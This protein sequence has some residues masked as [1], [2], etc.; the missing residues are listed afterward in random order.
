MMPLALSIAHSLSQ[1]LAVRPFAGR[2]VGRFERACN[3]VDGA[4]R[5]VALTLPEVGNGPFSIVISGNPGLFDSL[6]INQQAAADA[7]N[8]TIGQWQ[9]D[10][11]TAKIWEPKLVC[12]SQPLRLSSTITDSLKALTGWP[13]SEENSSILSHHLSEAKRRLNGAL[14]S[15]RA[16]GGVGKIEQAVSQLAGLGSGLT[17]AGDD[18]LMGVM[19]ALWLKG[20]REPLPG[21]AQVAAPR[22]TNLSAAFLKAAARGEYLELWHTLAQTLYAG[23]AEA[24]S[25][26][27]ERIAQFGASSGQEALAGFSITLLNLVKHEEL[28]S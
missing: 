17:P 23:E 27:V 6:P 15:A 13:H 22:T 1:E 14:I 10:L 26:A 4:G 24:F 11:K 2:V 16:N 20:Q 5:V 19:V 21:I 12:P 7:R 28:L 9:I 8:L 18:Y 3:L 25:R